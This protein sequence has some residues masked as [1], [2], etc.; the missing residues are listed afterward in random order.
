MKMRFSNV[1]YATLMCGLVACGEGDKPTEKP[2]NDKGTEN[3]EVKESLKKV[4]TDVPKPSELPYQIQKTGADF[5]EKTPNSPDNVEKYK[6]TTFKAALNLGVYASDI[7]YVAVHNKVQNAIKYINAAT[8][9]GDK[10][11]VSNA[12]DPKVK[13]RF[14]KNLKNIDSLTSIINESV[15]KSDAFLKSNDQSSTAALIF[16][17]VF[18]EGLYIATQII[19]NYGDELPK[20]VKDEILVDM[21]QIISQQDKPLNDLI[22]ALKSLEKSTDLD[23]LVAQLD[24]LSAIYKK[25]NIAD[26]IKQNKGNLILTDQTIKSISNKVKEIRTGMVS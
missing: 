22:A 11:G 16:A 17:G 15:S 9:L 7:G 8:Q 13:E 12:F 4:L 26:K 14:E 19:E 10:L 21:V 18:T 2:K 5:D 1:V 25:L 24:E 6:T 20:D 23:K 3:K